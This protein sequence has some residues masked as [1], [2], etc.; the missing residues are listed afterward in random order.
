MN[1]FDAIARFH[2]GYDIDAID[3][4]RRCW[5]DMVN[6]DPNYTTWEWIG[7]DGDPDAAFT[8]LAHAWSAGASFILSEWVLGVVPLEAGYK[9]YKIEPHT[10]SLGWAQGAIPSPRGEIEVNWKNNPVRF[11]IEL[12][13]PPGRG[14]RVSLPRKGENCKV[15][16]DNEL[17]FAPDQEIKSDKLEGSSSNRK[18][19]SFEL[20]QGGKHK[21][22]IEKT[23]EEKK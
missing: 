19:L 11:E 22:I 1:A 14:P 4:I 17:I 16:L 10:A 12:S 20:A 13:A 8:S 7:K 6:K 15:W 21:L 3:L 2:T 9:S 23:E 5:G 18:Y